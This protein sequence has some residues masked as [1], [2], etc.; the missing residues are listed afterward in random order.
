MKKITLLLPLLFSFF[1]TQLVFSQIGI[2]R[3]G[4][5]KVE[6]EPNLSSL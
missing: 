4:L 2:E 3:T 6:D 5:Q 1:T